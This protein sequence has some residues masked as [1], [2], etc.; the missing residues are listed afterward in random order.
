MRRRI[1]S[2]LTALCLCL[3]LLPTMA[4][5][6]ETATSVKVGSVEL[7][8]STPYLVNG[9]AAA[10]GTLGEGGCTA[11]FNAGTLHLNGAN[12][13]DTSTSDSNTGAIFALGTLTITL[14]GANNVTNNSDEGSWNCGI[15]V[16][17][18]L[19]INGTGTLTATGGTGFTSHGISVEGA[20]TIQS[21]TVN[22]IGREAEGSSGIFASED[23][24]IDGGTVTAR[25]ENASG[26]DSRGIESSGSI[27]IK[28]GSTVT[29]AAG[30]ATGQSY[31]MECVGTLT[32]EIGSNVTANG[33]SGA[34]NQ[35]PASE[36]KYNVWVAGTQVTSANKDGVTGDGITGTVT[37]DPDTRILTLDDATISHSAQSGAALSANGDLVIVLVEGSQNTVTNNVDTINDENTNGWA[38]GIQ[39]AN[40]TIRGAGSLTVNSG[41]I[42]DTSD[43]IYAE[44]NLKIIDAHVMASGGLS[45]GG[46]RGISAGGNITIQKSEV[47]AEGGV[48][49]YSVGI[50]TLPGN[51]T[52]NGG[53]V[54]A[55]GADAAT[56]YGINVG[57]DQNIRIQ[58]GRV[59]AKGETQAMNRAPDTNG[60]VAASE[61]TIETPTVPYVPEAISTYK[62]LCVDTAFAPTE[63]F[64]PVIKLNGVPVTGTVNFTGTATVTVE[65]GA[66]DTSP[67]L[68]YDWTSTATNQH[69][70]PFDG[71]APLR[72]LRVLPSMLGR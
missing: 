24:S 59:I 47:I 9:A 35:E 38:F 1:L 45:N 10:S 46:S 65:R 7:N 37:Y 8:S 61:S 70:G 71:T 27:T 15:R 28:S 55:T 29:A 50:E 17:G 62:Y 44:G 72:S 30:T 31:G 20:L 56:S 14:A 69:Y 2:I 26:G 25:G 43:G 66:G 67:I 48:A 60:A 4:M 11:Y 57:S 18:N 52:I 12:I 22:A 58:A 39:A 33:N 19:T 23:V 21:G 68:K 3:S 5:A 6:A 63:V 41:K 32:I 49:P 64:S 40:L 53:E 36:I 34:T 16:D 54:M 42:K 51:V 13:T